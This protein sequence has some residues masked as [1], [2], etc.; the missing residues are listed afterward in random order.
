MKCWR[1]GELL[2]DDAR[3]CGVCGS[4][5]ADTNIGRVLNGRF[6]LEERIGT[7]TLGAV[8]RAV[9]E[10][11]GRRVAVKVLDADLG[12]DP[13]AVERFR[14][15]GSVLCS[16]RSPHAITTYEFDST[17]EG[18][19]YIAM[20][21]LEGKSLASV[22]QLEGALEWPRAL[23]IV[24]AI[25]SALDEAHALGVVHRDLRPENIYLEPR[26]NEPDFVKVVD[27][28]LAKMARAEAL[29]AQDQTIG[30]LEYMSPEQLV[31]R[32]VDARTDVYALGILA[33]RMVT[34]EHPFA[35]ARTASAMIAAHV[36]R[37]PQPPSQR[38]RHLGLP[39][40]VDDI[41]ARCLE[42]EPHRRFPDVRALTALLDVVLAKPQA[43]TSDTIPE[44]SLIRGDEETELASAPDASGAPKRTR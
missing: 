19:L 43:T 22:L 8:Y 13:R 2:A 32:P 15:E 33:Y 10:G 29:T 5:L 20:E 41:V 27:F 14:R 25:C 18:T 24:R 42:K 16:L 35:D 17:P 21:L 28:G 9:R 1:C 34:G 40:D 11:I 6:R 31:R 23:K 7:G 36:E 44:S 3:F 4:Q 38:A 26:T 30:A 39:A 37:V 12:K